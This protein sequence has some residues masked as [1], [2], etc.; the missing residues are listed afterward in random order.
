MDRTATT[1]RRGPGRRV[2]LALC[3]A[4]AGV[5]SLASGAVHASPLDDLRTAYNKALGQYNNLELDQALAVLD[6]AIKAAPSSDDPALAPLM[7]LRAGVIFSNT[8][9]AAQ[10]KAA[11]AD[12]VKVDYNVQVPV[13]L[14]SDQFQKLL[15]EARNDAGSAPSESIRHSAPTPTC[16]TDITFDFL[17]SNRQDDGQVVF[18]W[19]TEGESDFQTI[20]MDTFG[21]LATAVVA[22][23]AHGD[24]NI[25]YLVAVF[26][27]N[28]KALAS[29]GAQDAPLKLELDCKKEEVKPDVKPE[30]PKPAVGLPRFHINL[31]LGT[32]L[33]VARGV[34]DLSYRQYSPAYRDGDTGAQFIYGMKE[35]ACS[36]ARWYYPQGSLPADQVTFQN[37]LINLQA[38]YGATL[39]P[40]T[41]FYGDNS[42][43]NIA[44]NYNQDYCNEHH[45][46]KSGMASAP[47]HIAPEFGFRVTDKLVVSVW[48]RLQV[49]TGS[50]VYRDDPKQSYP[51]SF[52]QTVYDVN[53]QNP[54]GV[55]IKPPFAWAVGA[56]VKYFLGKDDAKFRL[57]AGGFLGYGT[58]RLRVNMGFA[59]DRNGNS[60]P[61]DRE[62]GYD[63]LNE[64]AP[65]DPTSNPCTPVWPYNN[66]C[67]QGPGNDPSNPGDYDR[68]QA[69]FK[70]MNADKSPRIDTVGIGRFIIGGSFGFHYQLVKNFA[71]FGE[72]QLGGWVGGKNGAT[73]SFL[74]DLNVGPVITF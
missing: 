3:A 58:A 28:E 40:G 63:L 60:I 15:D 42:P 65:Y 11:L 72:L 70:K 69:G 35:Y 27:G 39:P 53:K 54:D 64:D 66:G 13:E 41:S 57:F 31:G 23:D 73:S 71:L 17:V 14:R 56:K 32:G 62:A 25:E 29:K 61:D 45:P 43:Q 2:T 9:D 5:L 74:I 4:L 34:A 48:T 68:L 49:V 16:G 6:E 37:D 51:D 67:V 38:M 30:E 22:A 19:R 50:K 44:L 8:G 20:N 59:N 36:I 33:G 21:N 1:G 26:D 47:F 24:K 12:A 7:I 46:V 55:R 18:Y 10:T 52:S